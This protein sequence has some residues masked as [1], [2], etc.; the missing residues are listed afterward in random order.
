MRVSSG[1]LVRRQSG[2]NK[3]NEDLAEFA[4][5]YLVLTEMIVRMSPSM[6]VVTSLRSANDNRG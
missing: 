2:Q 4:A 6:T 3:Q 1:G 5:G